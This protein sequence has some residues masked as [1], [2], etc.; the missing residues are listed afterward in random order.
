MSN[1]TAVFFWVSWGPYHLARVASLTADNN[2]SVDVRG[3]EISRLSSTYA[4]EADAANW[5]AKGVRLTTLVEGRAAESVGHGRLALLILRALWLLKPNV[6]FVPSYSP[7]SS[8]WVLVG[9]KL[10]GSKVV[11]MNETHARSAKDSVGKIAL[12]RL[13]LRLFDGA[14]VGGRPHKA[15]FESLGMPSRTILLGYDCVDTEFFV[16]RAAMARANQSVLRQKWKLPDQ[17]ILSLGRFEKKKNLPNL[18]SAYAK[19]KGCIREKLVFVGSGSMREQLMHLCAELNL[20]VYEEGS[21]GTADADVWFYAFKQLDEIPEFY[22]LASVFVLPSLT[23][24]WGLVV[25][26]AMSCGLPVVVSKYAGCASD[27]VVEGE[28]GFTFDPSHQIELEIVLKRL[29][30]DPLIREKIGANARDHVQKWGCSLFRENAERL[31]HW[32][33]LKSGARV[34]GEKYI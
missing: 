13:L 14:L 30:E 7:L 25:N 4:W 5:S 29:L 26:E 31:I 34:G 6:V 20:G 24:E 28:T 15:Y 18:I 11:M 17:F 22:S 21:A 23:E 3:L 12:K 1:L 8:I 27:L 16:E 2:C 19:I 32:N 10:I 33:L 9:A